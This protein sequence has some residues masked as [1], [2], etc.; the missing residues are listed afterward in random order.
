MKISSQECEIN[1]NFGPSK[2]SRKGFVGDGSLSIDELV[3]FDKRRMR[4]LG[5][6]SDKIAIEL[7]LVYVK[8]QKSFGSRVEIRPGLFSTFFEA[9][10]SIPSPFRG[11][12]V[13]DKGESLLIDR[14]TGTQIVITKLGIAM[15]KS[16]SFFQSSNSRYRI[17]PETVVSLLDI[18]CL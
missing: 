12:G 17:D 14:I 6:T 13:F 8:T 16:Y 10:G 9:R 7:E 2:F 11:H 3:A 18:S 5:V 4:F 15:I 1:A